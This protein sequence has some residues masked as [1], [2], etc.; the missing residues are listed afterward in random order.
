MRKNTE[1]TKLALNQFNGYKVGMVRGDPCREGSCSLSGG[2]RNCAQPGA[3]SGTAKQSDVYNFSSYFSSSSDFLNTRVLLIPAAMKKKFEKAK[4]KTSQFFSR[5]NSELRPQPPPDFEAGHF[6]SHCL[7]PPSP[8]HLAEHIFTVT[9]SDR[10]PSAREVR[11]YAEPTLPS[12]K[13]QTDNH[14]SL[15][16]REISA[17]LEARETVRSAK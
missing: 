16:S 13:K 15:L 9:S 7:A 6:Q 10:F 4:K 11:G 12:H 1:R 2:S 5:L 3:R 8:D 17:A 14:Q